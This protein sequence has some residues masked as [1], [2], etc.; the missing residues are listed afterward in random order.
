[1]AHA[2]LCFSPLTK[3]RNQLVPVVGALGLT[4]RGLRRRPHR[5]AATAAGVV[6]YW[7]QALHV[8]QVVDL[9]PRPRRRLAVA[10]GGRPA[11]HRPGA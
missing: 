11:L 2:R 7:R 8:T 6:A 9:T 5:G 4:A 10:I 1:M 3:R